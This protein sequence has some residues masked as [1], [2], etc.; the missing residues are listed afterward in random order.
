MRKM[1]GLI[2]E[3]KSSRVGKRT[4]GL[5][6]SLKGTMTAKEVHKLVR[7]KN[8]WGGLCIKVKDPTGRNY[9]GSA[10]VLYRDFKNSLRLTVDQ[11]RFSAGKAPIWNDKEDLVY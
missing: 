11:K 8:K 5:L 3:A 4:K 10:V 7:A 6:K 2:A 1:K 9:N